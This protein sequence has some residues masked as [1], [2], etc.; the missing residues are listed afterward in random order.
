T[1]I[2]CVRAELEFL[3]DDE[4]ILIVNVKIADAEKVQEVLGK[5]VSGL[6]TGKSAPEDREKNLRAYRSGHLKVDSCTKE[7]GTGI[8]MPFVRHVY[9]NGAP[10]S[11]IDYFQETGRAGRTGKESK[12]VVVSATLGAAYIPSLNEVGPKPQWWTLMHRYMK[13]RTCLRA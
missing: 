6:Y 12:A 3:G 11:I 9:H 2:R 7:F 5:N 1:V 4:Q 8:D 10:S 13:T